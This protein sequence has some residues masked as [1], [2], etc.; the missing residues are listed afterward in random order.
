[1]I[2][3]WALTLLHYASVAG[4]LVVLVLLAWHYVRTKDE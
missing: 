4:A 3:F 2:P 1:M